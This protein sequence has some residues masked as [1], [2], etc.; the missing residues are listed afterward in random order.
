[1]S[2]NIAV[3]GPPS[4]DLDDG[5]GALKVSSVV[6]RAPSLGTI[7]DEKAPQPDVVRSCP[8]FSAET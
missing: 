7:A 4:Q 6:M 2:I 1:M 5:L 8:W 3:V